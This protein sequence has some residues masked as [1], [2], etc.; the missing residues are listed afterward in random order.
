ME[1]VAARKALVANFQENYFIGKPASDILISDKHLLNGVTLRIS[2][3]RSTSDF[4][5]IS[6]S[7]THYKV[8]IFEANLYVIKMTRADHVLIAIE[9]NLLKIRTVYRYTEVLNELL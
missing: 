2:F 4:V 8:I 5:L 7:N 9:K 3:G 1:D 6:K